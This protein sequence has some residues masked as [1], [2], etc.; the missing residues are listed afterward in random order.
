[1]VTIT[2]E[3]PD[4]EFAEFVELSQRQGRTPNDVILAAA[5]EA[6]RRSAQPRPTIP[7]FSS[8]GNQTNLAERVDEAL[9]GFGED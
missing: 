3:M 6:I 7:L 2:I 5:R 1:M 9:A 4:H 8:R